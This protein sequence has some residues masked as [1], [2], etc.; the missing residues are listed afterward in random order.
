MDELHRQLI[1]IGL[2]ALAKDYG[3]ALAGGYAIQAHHIVNRVSDDVDLFAPFERASRE[4]EQAAERISTAYEAAG[5]TVEQ[6][7]LTP[8]YTRLN[9]TD[10]GSDTQSKVELVAEFLHHTPV[11]SELGPVLHRDDVAAGKTSALFTRAEVR[12]AIDVAGLLKAGYTREQLMDLAAQNDAG[13]D[14][15][16]F[17]DSLGRIQRYTDKQFAAYSLNAE[18]AAAI[19]DTFADWQQQLL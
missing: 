16:M 8:T 2:D 14:H 5:Y 18:D 11:D 7:H 15:R 9:V 4:M 13:F 19:R 17:A 1:R 6:V 10:P 12:D 3:Y